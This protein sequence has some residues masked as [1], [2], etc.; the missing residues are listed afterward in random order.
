MTTYKN[1]SIALGALGIA[2]G[3][4][5]MLRIA[6]TLRVDHVWRK[7]RATIEYTNQIRDFW[8]QRKLV[9]ENHTGKRVGGRTV[10]SRGDAMNIRDNA[11]LNDA[12]REFLARLEHLSAGTHEGVFDVD[13]ISRLSGSYFIRIYKYVEEYIRLAQEKNRSA[14]VDFQKLAM[15]L[16]ARK[17]RATNP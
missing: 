4:V 12:M 17:E 3:L 8:Q 5:V 9:I 14:Y 11:E 15:E 16:I 2:T 13:L 7:K 10:L 6:Q 1:F